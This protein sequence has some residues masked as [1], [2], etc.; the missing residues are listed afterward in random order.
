MAHQFKSLESFSTSLSVCL[1]I[2][3]N[4]GLILWVLMTHFSW[5]SDNN[6]ITCIYT[7]YKAYSYRS[8][9]HIC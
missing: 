1:D 2:T 4:F 5:S 6:L 9:S 3:V 7:Y 8:C